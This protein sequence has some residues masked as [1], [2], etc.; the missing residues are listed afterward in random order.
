MQSLKA[1]LCR[2]EQPAL[3]PRAREASTTGAQHAW[4]GQGER[5]R[6]GGRPG[7]GG[8]VPQQPSPEV[9]VASGMNPQHGASTLNPRVTPF[10]MVLCLSGFPPLP[11]IPS[12]HR[13]LPKVS[14]SSSPQPPPPLPYISPLSR[15]Q[16]LG[17]ANDALVTRPQAGPTSCL[18]GH[19]PYLGF[20]PLSCPQMARQSHPPNP[21]RPSPVLLQASLCF[22]A[23]QTALFIL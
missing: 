20:L 7:Q 5:E 16:T 21:S 12:S 19:S 22:L 8:G 14:F 9:L 6:R 11:P 23:L 2:K 18:S 13:S 17:R 15:T 4:E 10:W 1:G 3:S